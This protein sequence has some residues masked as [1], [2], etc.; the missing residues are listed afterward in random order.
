MLH[1]K[2][3]TV[4]NLMELA[5]HP[6]R[7]HGNGF[8]QLD[9]EWPYRL[10][11]WGPDIPRQETPTPIHNHVF[12]FYSRLLKGQMFNVRYDLQPGKDYHLYKPVP[13][14]GEDTELRLMGGYS[15]S[16]KQTSIDQLSLQGEPS[17]VTG[18]F[19]KRGDFHETEPLGNAVTLIGILPQNSIVSSELYPM[20][21]VKAHELPDNTFDRHGFSENYLW[22]LIHTII[23]D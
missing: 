16:V 11:F 15:T 23:T 18:Y 13:R 5:K 8:I 21:L 10:N 12:D 1:S 6:P 22:D 17:T 14:H 7:V 9:L 2:N 19:M 3:L 20:V 4:H